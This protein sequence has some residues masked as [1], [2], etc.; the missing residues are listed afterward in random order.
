MSLLPSI[1]RAFGVHESDPAFCRS[2]DAMALQGKNLRN[3]ALYVIRQFWFGLLADGS[4]RPA[5]LGPAESAKDKKKSKKATAARNAARIDMA[6][7]AELANAQIRPINAMRQDKL[8]E[9][10]FALV[11]EVEGPPSE[12]G[13]EQNH[14]AVL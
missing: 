1:I 7:W 13:G 14:Q 9:K 12:I 5:P 10:H 6:A 4:P 8:V 11:P 3:M 2:V